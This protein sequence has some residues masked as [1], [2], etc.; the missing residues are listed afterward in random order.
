[1]ILARSESSVEVTS[2]TG[3]MPS[4]REQFE[5]AC[6]SCH[7]WWPFLGIGLHPNCCSQVGH[8]RP[9]GHSCSSSCRQELTLKIKDVTKHINYTTSCNVE[10]ERV[11]MLALK[12]SPV[13][14]LQE[15]DIFFCYPRAIITH[16]LYLGSLAQIS[17][18]KIVQDLKLTAF[19]NCSE[20]SREITLLVIFQQLLSWVSAW[21]FKFVLLEKDCLKCILCQYC[22]FEKFFTV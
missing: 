15:L 7:H 3:D 11:K 10:D 12:L 16:K 5:I 2:I 19:V 18:K 9:V 4:Y 8:S 14:H 6:H 17:N 13:I 20:E 21:N 22:H 1:M